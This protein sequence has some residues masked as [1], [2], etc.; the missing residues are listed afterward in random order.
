MP[1]VALI[2]IQAEG[3]QSVLRDLLARHV[4]PQNIGIGACHEVEEVLRDDQEPVDGI[5]SQMAELRRVV[6][7]R[8]LQLLRD[9]EVGVQLIDGARALSYPQSGGVKVGVVVGEDCVSAELKLLEQPTAGG[10]RHLQHVGL[11]GVDEIQRATVGRR[12]DGGDVD[13]AVSEGDV[14]QEQT[15]LVVHEHARVAERQVHVVRAIECE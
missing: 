5:H 10:A 15:R 13:G 6:P 8:Q 9:G 14:P 11:V 4:E 7:G 12:G 3:R 2:T 1:H